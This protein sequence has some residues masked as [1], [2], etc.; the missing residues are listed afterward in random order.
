[1]FKRIQEPDV[2]ANT[3]SSAAE[4]ALSTEQPIRYTTL[5]GSVSLEFVCVKFKVL[6]AKKPDEIKI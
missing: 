1:L 6:A 4:E 2:S 3:W 5:N